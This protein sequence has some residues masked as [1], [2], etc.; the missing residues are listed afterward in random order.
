MLSFSGLVLRNLVYHARGNLA[1]LLG[2]AVGSAVFTGALLV[3][4]SLRGSLRDRVERQLGGVD[5]VAFFPRPVRAGIADGMPGTVKPVLLVPGA[6]QASGDPATAPYLGK[7]TVLG[8][9]PRSAPGGVSEV[10]WAGDVRR[11]RSTNTFPPVVLSYRVADKLNAKTGD[12]VTLSAERFSDLPRSSSLAKR[13]SDDVTTAEQFTVAAVLPPEAPENDF[14]LTPNPAAP[15]NVFVP[16]RTLARMVT[17]DAEPVATV[18]L[19]SDAPHDALNAALKDRLRPEDYG[20]KFREVARRLGRGGYLSVESAELILPPKVSDAV[21][22]AA[23][24]VGARA[25]PTVV[26]VADTL[27]VGDKQ[28]PYPIVAGLNTTAPSPLSPHELA[29]IPTPSL[30][31]DEVELLTWPGSE[32]NRLPRGT[33]VKL[34]YF[35][36]EVEGEGLKR[37]AELTLSGYIPLS[38]PA[39]DKDLTPEIKGVTDDRANLFDWD[40]PPVLPGAE[41]KR[42]VPE[43]PTPHPRGTFFNQNKAVPMAYLNLAT[44]RKLF[45]SRYG[46]DT[47]VRVA[48]ANNEPLDKFSERL[49]SELPKHLDPDSAGL[50]FDPVRARLLTASKGGTDFGG[51]FLGFSLFLI[52]AALMLVGLLFRLSIDRRAKEVGL[53]LATGFAVKHVRRLLLAEGLL[54]AVLGAALGLIAGV[55]YN[56]LLLVVLLDL[57]PD[58]G[59][60]AYFQPHASALSF[61]LGFGITVLMALAAQWWS[62]RELVR[63]APPALLRGETALPAGSTDGTGLVT[64]IVTI[65]GLV[66]GIALIAAGGTVSNPDFRAMTFFGGGG[67][68]LTAALAAVRWWMRRTRHAVVNGRG[69]SALAKLGT[70][71]AARNPA[72]SLLTA[73]LL[74]SAAFLLVAV[75]SFRR[76]PESDFLDK[77]GGSGGFNLLAEADVPLFQP[78]DSGL[79]RADLEKQLQKAYAPP[80]SDPDAPP[81][82]DAY[83]AAKADLSAGLEEV[84][85]LRLRGG[86]DAS[87]MNLFQAARPRVLGVPEAL[88]ARGGF[89]FYMT[90]AA[91]AEEK[92]NPWLLLAKPAPNN[93]VPVFCENNTAQWMLK[94]AIGDEFAMPGDDGAEVRFRIVGTL[95]DSPFQSEVITSDAAFV[96]AFPKQTGYRAFL[97]RTPAAKQT[98]VARALEI[99]FRA[100]GLAATPTRDKVASFQAVIGAYLSTFQLLGGFG[101]LLGVLGLAVVVLRGV[102]ERLGELALLRAVGYRTRALQFLVIVENGLLLL[103]GLGAGV[104]TALASVAPHVLSGAAIPW[105]R[106]G[107]MLGAVLVA[108]LTVATVATAGVLRVPVIPALRRE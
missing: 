48:P 31:D 73:A 13:S 8:I 65:G 101:L 84:F 100:N 35:D 62:V 98:A 15:L 67:L 58:Q 57:W 60:K 16:V 78:F 4:D 14:N 34:V 23:Q 107:L 33:K 21:R 86:D 72:R 102:W 51:L 50:V 32:L 70:R 22:S 43:K 2:V 85:P 66:V 11:N 52:A 3:G 54:V 77:S 89:K 24:A 87:C 92:A 91:S 74:A 12:T 83:R 82:T 25:E 104:L 105:A 27:A 59:V 63:I 38:G 17:G 44:A 53:L 68:L 55:A 37:E 19:A 61:A 29:P 9:D 20:L 36:P 76:T 64:K 80:G 88:I 96:K 95:V 69:L 47:S 99:G 7:V 94:K 81:D 56:R 26:Y 10:D 71:N 106:L 5:S 97:I 18:L 79:G 39:R 49:Q 28:I 108:G 46:T 45:R 41:I 93:A 40:R 75:E 6:V 42:R 30:A 90:E 103:V 1:V